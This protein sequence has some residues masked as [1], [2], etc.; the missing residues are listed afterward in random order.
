MSDASLGQ[1]LLLSQSAERFV[2]R[3]RPAAR[4]LNPAWQGLVVDDVIPDHGGRHETFE[5]AVIR[6]SLTLVQPDVRG[7]DE[8]VVRSVRRGPHPVGRAIRISQ[9]RLGTRLRR[10]SAVTKAQPKVSARAR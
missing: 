5:V 9:R 10:A 3:S 1:C 4:S 7:T 6:P 2:Q 8:H